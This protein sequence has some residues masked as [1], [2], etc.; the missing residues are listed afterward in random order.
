MLYAYRG[1]GR[2]VVVFVV[3]APAAVVTVTVVVVVVVAI[4]ASGL[5][6]RS[7]E[8]CPTAQTLAPMIDLASLQLLPLSSSGSQFHRRHCQVSV[9]RPL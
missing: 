2:T 3:V 7:S 4:C 6:Q 9:L 1:V 5:A 8:L